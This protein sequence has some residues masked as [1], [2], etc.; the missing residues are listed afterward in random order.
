M[1]KRIGAFSTLTLIALAA[2]G[3]AP[4]GADGPISV[5]GAKRAIRSALHA[6]FDGGIAK[7]SLKL[8]PCFREQHAVRCGVVLEDGRGRSWHGRGSAWPEPADGAIT[9]TITRFHLHRA[10][11]G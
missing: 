2:T 7:G 1:L 11:R 8:G 4:A 5:E 3:A 10:T 9:R 6:D